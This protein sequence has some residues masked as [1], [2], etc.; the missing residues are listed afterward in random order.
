M[1]IS[2]TCF[3]WPANAQC[4]GAVQAHLFSHVFL[5]YSWNSA[6]KLH[7]LSNSFK[8]KSL[9]IE[10]ERRGKKAERMTDRDTD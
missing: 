3:L 2:D 6:S 7:S 1:V 9:R 5:S 4:N 8:I 10:E